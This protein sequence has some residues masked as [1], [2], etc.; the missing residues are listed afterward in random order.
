MKTSILPFN[1]FI[2]LLI[3][4]Y[5]S[6]SIIHAQEK[7]DAL[8][9]WMT[10]PAEEWKNALPVGNGR[11]GAMVFGGINTERL[12]LNEETVWTGKDAD[13]H[14][15]QSREGLKEVRK[16]LF[17][18]KYTEAEA[19][20]LKKIMGQRSTDYSQTYQTLGDL[21]IN[22]GKQEHIDNYRRELDIEN[23]IAKVSYHANYTRYT[24]EIFSSAV[25]QVIVIKLSA[26]RDSALNF[27]LRY[28]RPGNMAKIETKNNEFQISEHVGNGTGVKM[29]ARIRIIAPTGNV[30][31]ATDS[32]T[33]KNARSAIVLIAA[34]T[35]Y[36]GGNPDEITRKQINEAARKDHEE[37]KSA[38][39]KDYRKY[40]DRVDLDLGTTDAVYFP[41]NSRID[42]MKNGNTD[43]QLIELY[44]QFGRYMLIS[45]SRP[46]CLPANL[47]GIWA[48]GLY[49]PW[50]ADYHININIQMNYWPAEI[51]NLS[52]LH[53]P[54]LEFI[55]ALREDGRKT[56]KEVYGCKGVMTHFTTD[57]W[58]YTEP[59]GDINWGMWPMGM[60]WCCQHHWEH[61]LFTEDKDYLQKLGYPVMKDA[62]EFCIDW[63]IIDP[64]TGKLVSGPSIS[65]ENKFITTNGEIAAMV[66]GPTMD[67]M[68][69][70][71]L[72]SNTIEASKVLNVDAGFR[73]KMEKTLLN[74][75]P[76]QI[77]SD[78]RLM[79]WTEEF[80]EKNPG[81][82]HISHLFGL[83]PGHQITKQH[84][85]EFLEAARKTIDY[86]LANGGGH[87]GW[88]RA[89]IIN[90]F[91]R[92]QDGE[93]A[94]ENII[95]L[96]R[97]STLDNLFD[98][99][100]PFQ[101]DGN[102]GAVAGITE[103]LMQ[104]HTGEIHLLP[105]LPGAWQ[106]GHVNGIC[107]RGGY[108]VN[109]EWQN[110]KLKKVEIISKL[111]NDCKVSYNDKIIEFKTEKGKS[112]S[113]DGELNLLSKG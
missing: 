113:F 5:I 34:A 111:G 69:I 107:S 58:H 52:E 57:P 102:F 13:F 104:S 6:A 27:S 19:V 42:A 37:L 43:P 32:I 85:P 73:E 31:S 8:K 93:A 78:G 109:I 20:A 74:L 62:A 80:K 51:T 75:A 41:T 86:R 54:F 50:S 12:Q 77:G 14:N 72:L 36:R 68:I 70:W 46:G 23:A 16:L 87:T 25:N 2:F 40:F 79:E 47:Q 98:T 61:Y 105:A 21:F 106:Q 3:F 7:P 82:R 29:Y 4:F 39:I 59:F 22:F 24:R 112:Y 17:E 15:P 35:D 108:D 9:I 71:D 55:D 103:M 44:Y 48:D 100:P 53:I 95:A 33:V 81:H 11:L 89:W 99:H 84:N 28:T 65:P 49:P 18:G 88:S 66:M 92:L 1:H 10:H 26:K 91:A 64:K 63:L 97:K 45:S 101:V 60:A 67:Q 56:A 94:Y 110:G 38:H 96:L 90:F 30:I 83:H 76:V